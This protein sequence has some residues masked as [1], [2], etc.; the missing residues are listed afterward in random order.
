MI[1]I[2]LIAVLSV[3]GCAWLLGLVTLLNN[4]RKVANLTFAALCELCGC[5]TLVL[6]LSDHDQAHGLLWS[7]LTFTLAVFM[8]LAMV[9]FVA[10]FPRR[11]FSRHYQ[12]ILSGISVVTAVVTLLPGFIPSVVLEPLH[13]NVNTGDLYPVFMAY[14]AIY[15]GLSIFSMYRARHVTSNLE[16][17]RTKYVLT[18]FFATAGLLTLTN[19]VLPLITGNDNLSGYGSYFILILIGSSAYAV[20]RQR[21]FNVRLVVARSVAYILLLTALAGIYT[22]GLIGLSSLFFTTSQVSET[23]NVVYVALAMV[24]ALTFQPLRRFFERVTDKVF[25]R[26]RYDSQE[27]LS[28]FSNVLVTEFH[29]E[30]LLSRSLK[31]LSTDLNIG[32]AQLI[33]FRQ[34]RV[35]KVEHH[36][37]LPKRLIVAPELKLLT[38]PIEVA[39]E[40]EEGPVK[41]VL[42]DHSL[43]LVA[44]LQTREGLIGYL[45][46]GTK[47]SGDIYSSQDIDVIGIMAKELA[48]AVSN[49]LAYA[50]IQEFAITLQERVNHATN[51][52]RVANR[53]LKEL[54]RV[55][56]EFLSLASHQLR[57]PLTTIKGYLSM[58]LEG[59]AG[60]M[61]STQTEFI[62]YAYDG[63]ERMVRLIA[64]LLNVSR[65]SAGRF[66]IDAKP[67]DAVAMVQDEVRQLQSHAD[68]KGLS[69]TFVAPAKKLPLVSLDE[70]KT[71]QVIMNFIDN[72]I[73]YTATGGVTVLLGVKK[74]Q[75]RL[76]VR[77]TGIG[78]PEEAKSHLF[79]K[80]FRAD[81]AQGVRP[82]GTGLGLYLAKRVI[83]DQGGTIVFSSTVGKGSTF[84]FELPLVPAPKSVTKVTSNAS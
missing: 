39:D 30:S 71:R 59:D 17:E 37:P 49:S 16:R 26:D 24:V 6:F 5:Y 83:E 79:T 4:S 38:R 15:L 34:G 41:T 10:N 60:K 27:V 50:E 56:D 22:A 23:Q 72:A 67:T 8:L 19:L 53:H 13:T 55:K 68:G 65:L 44:R 52:L 57:T 48:V 33:I 9:L 1:S 66:V 62:S 47:L 73:Y 7:R 82:D 35:Y 64:D 77:D 54:D 75:L 18:G 3:A 80:F 78:V 61:S 29:L 45:L 25:Y 58:L 74:G 2:S 76:E 69:L 40:L 51:R 84:G 70:N 31:Q 11:I 46:L 43:R 42:E 81:N 12:L 32:F 63:S 28:S 20:I 14:L 36:G 21:L